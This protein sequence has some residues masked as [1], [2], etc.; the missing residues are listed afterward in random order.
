MDKGAK[1]ALKPPCV[2]PSMDRRRAFGVCTCPM[3]AVLALLLALILGFASQAEAVARS[4]MAGATTAVACGLGV[5]TLD[6]AGKPLPAKPCTHCLAAHMA[7]V[8]APPPVL[9][10][11]LT[12]ATRAGQAQAAPAPQ[13]PLPPAL[14]RGP[15][16]AS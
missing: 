4:E 16:L 5:V 9:A 10:A 8:I 12:R 14:A 2:T 3:R 15:P 1:P 6:A 11:P 7:A 13:R